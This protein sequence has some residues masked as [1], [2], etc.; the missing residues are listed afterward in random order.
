MSDHERSVT[1]KVTAAIVSAKGHQTQSRLHINTERE[2][3]HGTTSH[4]FI[5]LFICLEW[6]EVVGLTRA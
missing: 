5:Y 1:K 4:L 2:K 3:F 6:T